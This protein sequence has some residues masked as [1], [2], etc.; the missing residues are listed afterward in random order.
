VSLYF[1]VVLVPVLWLALRWDRARD[2]AAPAPASPAVS[3]HPWRTAIASAVV[4]TAAYLATLA[5]WMLRNLAVAGIPYVTSMQTYVGAW[6]LPRMTGA[7]L[8]GPT[9][10][11]VAKRDQAKPPAARLIGDARSFVRGFVRYFTILGSGE[12]PLILGI[13]YGRHD[14]IG[15]REAG[16]LAWAKATLH[17]RS[18]GLERGIVFSI[19]LYLVAIY[20]AAARGAWVALR[21]GLRSAVLLLIATIVYFMV[22]TGPIAREVRYR[23]PAWPAIVLLAGLGLTAARRGEESVYNSRSSDAASSRSAA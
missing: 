2:R 18:S 20:L 21:R 1:I 16:L 3:R 12:Y 8:S 10:N 19:A 7:P 22:A 23:L 11:D 15:L 14:A 9:Q 13:R 4:L 17:N 5:P 6:Y